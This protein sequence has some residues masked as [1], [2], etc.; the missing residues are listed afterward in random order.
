MRTTYVYPKMLEIP[1]NTI[2]LLLTWI[3]ESILQCLVGRRLSVVYVLPIFSIKIH[4]FMCSGCRIFN[5]KS[6]DCKVHSYFL[7]EVKNKTV[8]SYPRVNRFFLEGTQ[9]NANFL[10]VP[11]SFLTFSASTYLTW[12]ISFCNREL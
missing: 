5:Y 10:I 9:N 1:K 3:W 7:Q 4:I 12:K 6:T 11:L 8:E 2:L